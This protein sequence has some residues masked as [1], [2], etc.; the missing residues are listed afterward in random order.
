MDRYRKRNDLSPK[1]KDGSGKQA[2]H[3]WLRD[4]QHQ[5]FEPTLP[6]DASSLPMT[7][8]EMES[9]PS[10]SHSSDRLTQQEIM[11]Q[12]DEWVTSLPTGTG[13]DA[14]SSYHS[15]DMPAPSHSLYTLPYDPANTSHPTMSETFGT[16]FDNP[17]SHPYSSYSDNQF[18]VSPPPSDIHFDYQPPIS[19]QDWE[20][21]QLLHPAQAD[22]S[23]QQ[24]HQQASDLTPMLMLH[25]QTSQLNVENR[26][27]T[28]HIAA[29]QQETADS[30]T[31][32]RGKR[33]RKAG[34]GPRKKAR[35]NMGWEHADNNPTATDDLL[36][37]QTSRI[38]HEQRQPAQAPVG[39][40]SINIDRLRMDPHNSLL[41][42][43][44][45][46]I[47]VPDAARKSPD[48]SG[49]R[50]S[51]S[52]DHADTLA[53]PPEKL[54]STIIRFIQEKSSSA[55]GKRLNKGLLKDLRSI[56]LDD[57]LY[58]QAEKIIK[59]TDIPK[60]K[61][62]SL[63]NYFKIMQKR[64]LA[65]R[66]A[67]ASGMVKDEKEFYR[68]QTE[69]CI[70]KA[71]ASGIVK[72]KKDFHRKQTEKC[73]EKAIALGMVKDEK[74]FYRKRAEK[75]IEKAIA[76]GIVKDKKEFYHIQTEKSIGKAIDSGIVK[77]KEEFYR[78]KVEK[79]IEKAIALGIVKDKKEFYYIQREKSIEKAID[80]GMIKDKKEFY[81]QQTEKRIK[82]AIDSGIVKDKE[83]FF[84]EE[85]TKHK[86]RLNI[87]ANKIKENESATLIRGQEQQLHK[88]WEQIQGQ[89]H[90]L[91]G[92]LDRY[93]QLQQDLEQH[94]F[95]PLKYTNTQQNMQD[96]DRL[97]AIQE[98]EFRWNLSDLEHQ[99]DLQPFEENEPW[100]ETWW[101]DL[102]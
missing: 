16:S 48:A 60:E 20:L 63:L 6:M 34:S 81:R 73:I 11:R 33:G 19:L 66:K 56:V 74:E 2:H 88:T 87:I 82:K 45:S 97:I 1:P 51:S 77:D 44:S 93:A 26:P 4:K 30:S 85:Y 36:A 14:S 32:P 58:K 72:D 29:Q 22:A 101:D 53:F 89:S 13:R 55:K 24:T 70:E 68:Q 5:N 38:A 35:T 21:A 100:N 27:N 8:T 39:P 64:F 25:L 54:E 69:K 12:L 91:S 96:I 79:S 15:A 42:P 67:I 80:S 98:E 37:Q 102:E 84:K 31:Q 86:M 23:L 95:D 40:S 61:K 90:Q 52:A 7:S 3:L 10:L 62:S 94:D 92:L 57:D 78:K 59:D 9:I 49:E 43:S 75:S 46:G 28:P 71:I 76:L 83:E 65:I 47:Q 50:E 41:N 18:L 99:L 17:S